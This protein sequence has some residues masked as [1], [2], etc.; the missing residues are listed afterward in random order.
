M[1]NPCFLCL[2]PTYGGNV[3]S[4][5]E[6][7]KATTMAVTLVSELQDLMFSSLIP[8][9]VISLGDDNEA[10]VCIDTRDYNIFSVSHFPYGRS[11]TVHDVRSV[12]EYY[13]RDRDISLDEF[14]LRCSHLSTSPT[15]AASPTIGGRTT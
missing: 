14:A 15:Y 7:N 3:I 9:L 2:L 12:I 6:T 1:F 8:D 4:H 5:Q 10:E 13:L 11:I